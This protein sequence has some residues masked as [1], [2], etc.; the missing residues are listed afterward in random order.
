MSKS[1]RGFTLVELLVVIA[2]IGLLIALLLP[3]VQAARESARRSQCMNNLKQ[4][5][6]GVHNFEDTY[7]HVPPLGGFQ[8]KGQ[9]VTLGFSRGWGLLPFMLPYVEQSA[10]FEQI[11]FD[12]EVCCNSH[13]FLK[14]THVPAFYCPSDPTD[15]LLPN[16]GL[17]NNTCNDGSGS[18][19][20]IVTSKI[21]HYVGSFGDGFIVGENQGYTHTA[22]S[23]TIY[24]CGGC[25]ENGANTPTANCPYPGSGFGGGPRHRGIFN[26]LGNT[27]PVRF[28]E[29]LDGLS[30]TIMLGHTAGIAMGY[31]NVWFTNTGNVNG[32]SL[33]INFN[34]RKSLQQGS[35][36]CPNQC[37][38]GQSNQ[39]RPWT[40]RGFQSH[41]PGGSV[42]TMA[43]GSTRFLM[44]S[45]SMKTYNALGSRKGGETVTPP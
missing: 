25:N 27:H 28:N 11:N 39:G 36:W 4:I 5:G 42:F 37:Q 18:G 22:T 1:P 12:A 26:Y 41:H 29:V 40:G 30:N 20:N 43:D 45:I 23:R 13:N 31:D 3:A 6:L 34:I 14:T 16:R 35:F 24:G 15:T 8:L 32:T 2:I 44:E 10:V 19:G 33:P 9:I 38:F 7:K 21:T 17:P